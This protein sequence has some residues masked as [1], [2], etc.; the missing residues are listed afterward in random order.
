MRLEHV[1]AHRVSRREDCRDQPNDGRGTR[2]LDLWERRNRVSLWPKETTP[3]RWSSAAHSFPL[4]TAKGPKTDR[5]V[6][7]QGGAPGRGSSSTMSRW[8]RRMRTRR[9]ELVADKGLE[10]AA[11]HTFRQPPNECVP[12][13]PPDWARELRGLVCATG[14]FE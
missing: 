13:S 11:L 10:L 4:E 8:T 1:Q 12:E 6:A 3:C 5:C 9:S 14:H 2:S 7:A